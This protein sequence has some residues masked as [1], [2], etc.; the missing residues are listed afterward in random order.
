MER[1]AEKETAQ[2]NNHKRNRKTEGRYT[3][4]GS[5]GKGD[6]DGIKRLGGQETSDDPADSNGSA[7]SFPSSIKGKRYSLGTARLWP[8][9]N[10]PGGANPGSASKENGTGAF[11]AGRQVTPHTIKNRRNRKRDLSEGSL[12]KGNLCFRTEAGWAFGRDPKT[13]E[14]TGDF[15]K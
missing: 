1:G 9:R 12:Q 11:L 13:E 15:G 10:R 3:G 6:T 14:C 5:A 4:S 2:R 8:G 7:G